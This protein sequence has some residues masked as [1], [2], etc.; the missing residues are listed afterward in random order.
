[1]ASILLKT[2]IP[3]MIGDWH[4][5]RFSLL[6]AL[7]RDLGHGVVARDR[8][9][10][11][12]NDPDLERARRGGFDQVWLFG[13]C[14]ASIP[15]TGTDI[16]AIVQFHRSGG[17]LLLSR[18]HQD[19]GACF[20]RIGTLG[21]CHHFHSTNPEP[22]PE[23]RVR[24]DVGTP[25]ISWPNYHAGRNGDAHPIETVGP[26]HPLVQRPDGDPIQ[27]FPAHPHKGVVC[28]PPSL[29]DRTRVIARARSLRSGA[30]FNLVVAVDAVPSVGGRAVVDA[31]FHHFCDCNWDPS[32]GAPS[33]VTEPWGEDIAIVPHAR[34]DAE[35]YAAN[36]ATWLSR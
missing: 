5:G 17:G 16:D 3:T 26:V 9:D 18:D 24:D 34:S 27:W 8:E 23:R 22:E 31:S 32:C 28:A 2:T 29:G 36:I 21:A 4:I 19:L 15:L 7:L 10:P 20:A 33:F 14:D 1:M 13:V 30:L 11:S 35:Q 6:A 12:V 25:E